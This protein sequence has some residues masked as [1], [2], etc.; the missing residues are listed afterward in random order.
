[1]LSRSTHRRFSEPFVIT[2]GE[3][4]SVID[5]AASLGFSVRRSRRLFYL[6]RTSDEGEAFMRLRAEMDCQTAIALGDSPLDAEYLSRAELPI[7][8]PRPDGIADPELM[9]LPNVRIAPAP[10]SAGWAAAVEGVLA[11]LT[12]SAAALRNPIHRL[13]L[14]G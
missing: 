3:V 10:G 8:I 5:A 12:G 7:V 2:Q 4:A 13:D 1:M 9:K 6:C 14:A 11:E